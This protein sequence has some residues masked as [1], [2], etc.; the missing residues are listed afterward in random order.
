MDTNQIIILIPSSIIALATVI[1]TIFSGKTIC[2]LNKQNKLLLL[3]SHNKLAS[4]LKEEWKSADY[5]KIIAKVKN[6]SS[7]SFIKAFPIKPKNDSPEQIKFFKNI[8][9]AK[10]LT[11]DELDKVIGLT[12]K[13]NN[14]IKEGKL[15]ID[16]ILLYF[17]FIYGD[18][19]WVC[20]ENYNIIIDMN[21]KSWTQTYLS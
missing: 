3:D 20:N 10:L 7:Y 6:Y 21:P 15:N 12:R 16:T 17:E 14:L 1:Y 9:N 18:T 13:L 19:E 4:F 5:N 8:K 11:V 2:T